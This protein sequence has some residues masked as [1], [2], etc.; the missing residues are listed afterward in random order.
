MRT[1]VRTEEV[2]EVRTEEVRTE[3][4]VVVAVASVADRARV[5]AVVETPAVAVDAQAAAEAATVEVGRA[6]AEAGRSMVAMAVVLGEQGT[7]CPLH[8][9]PKPTLPASCTLHSAPEDPALLGPL[10]AGAGLGLESRVG[11]RIQGCD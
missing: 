1:E 5:V 2:V 9:Q 10:G 11:T 3:E 4:V 8:P 7:G 6:M